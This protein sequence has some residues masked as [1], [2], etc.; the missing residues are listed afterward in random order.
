[1]IIPLLT[2]STIDYIPHF[3]DKTL[4]FI[5]ISLALLSIILYFKHGIVKLVN[6]VRILNSLL[7][8]SSKH[9]YGL[10]LLHT[11][12]LYYV[13]LLFG[14]TDLSSQAGLAIIRM[15]LV[16]TITMIVTIPFTFICDKIKGK[17]HKLLN[18]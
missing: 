4:Y 18:L 13:E 12:V 17:L 14:W 5:L 7:I 8:Y 2:E 9:S 10:F 6:E 3:N 15:L 16:I 1:M 11:I